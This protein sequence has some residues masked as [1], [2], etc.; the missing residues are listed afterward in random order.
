MDSD[1]GS[2]K[3]KPYRR[4]LLKLSGEALAGDRGYGIEPEILERLARE[5]RVVY[6]AGIEIG[7]VLGGGNIFRGFSASVKG[8]DRVS[9]DYMGMLATGINS[10][11]VQDALERAGVMTRVMSAISMNQICEPFITRR[12]K[13]H[14]EKGRVVIFACGTGNPYFTTDTA[15]ALR[16][17]EIGAEIILK[18]TK[19]D[20]VF[21]KDPMKHDDAIMYRN[22]SYMEVLKKK[23]AVMD[24]TAVS[25]CMGEK[26][27]IRVFNITTDGNIPR[28]IFGEDIG[29][30]VMADDV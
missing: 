28:V 20:G 10:L 30:H 5:I 2:G 24:A 22:L 9:A 6:D 3:V 21:D 25:L 29:T 13:R 26:L 8:M 4:V 18:A 1:S 7:L 19:V 14:L 12:A 15:A 11:A 16:A 17:K 23:I 27:P